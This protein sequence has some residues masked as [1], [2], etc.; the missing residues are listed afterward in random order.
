[1]ATG[2][3]KTYTAF[4]I[5]YRLWKSR[6]KKKILFIA[7]RNILV[8]QTMQNDFKPFQK[9]MTKIENKTIDS[10]YEVY[11][12]LY[13]QLSG[14]EGEEIFKE[15]SPEFFDLIVIDEAMSS[16]AQEESRSISENVKWGHRKRFADGKVTVPFG[17]FLGYKRGEDGN[18]VIDEEQAVIVKR[19]YREYLSGST[20][21]A[22]AKGLTNDGIETPGH[23]QKW[24][25]STVRSIL[26]NEKYKGEFTDGDK[27]VIQD[28]HDRLIKNK[29]LKNI[30]QNND[31]QMF[32][33]SMFN[34]FFEDAAQD[35]YAEA[36]QSYMSLFE[37]P[38]KYSAIKS[39]LASV[40]YSELTKQPRKEVIY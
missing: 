12:A 25:A 38:A 13:Q 36:Q 7:D 28:L 3:G 4:Q 32:N 31:S 26:T 5:I 35:G 18:L 16:L 22:I 37:D 14:Q 17:N 39:A 21:V 10:S 20:A 23:K 29:K 24:H 34:S 1:M 9:V 8:D 27:V 33:D 30:A 19:I 2:T 15:F 40:L 6:Q 11:L